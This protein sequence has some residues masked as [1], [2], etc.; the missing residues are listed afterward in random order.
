MEA[1]LQRLSDAGLPGN[2]AVS[3]YSFLVTYTLGFVSYTLNRPWGEDD[4]AAA[5]VRRQRGHFYAGLPIDEFPMMVELSHEL[6]ELPAQRQYDL[7][8]TA[9]IEHVERALERAGASSSVAD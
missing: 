4:D 8:V 5:E 7:G 9:F 1:L 3:C 6:L 2:V